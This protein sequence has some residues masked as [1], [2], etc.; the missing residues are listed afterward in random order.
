MT[1]GWKNAI[2]VK[3]RFSKNFSKNLTS[4][5]FEIKKKLRNKASKQRT[6]VI[7][8]YWEKLSDNVKSDPEKLAWRREIFEFW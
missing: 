7:R 6:I 8:Q 5:N 4:E 3:S 2:K 1:R